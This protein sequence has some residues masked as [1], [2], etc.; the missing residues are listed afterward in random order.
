MRRS[1]VSLL[2][3]LSFLVPACGDGDEEAPFRD[4]MHLQYEFGIGVDAALIDVHVKKDGDEHWAI[5]IQAV[6]D[7]EEREPTT[8]R[9]DRFGKTPSG[10]VAR[11][12][13]PPLWLPPGMREA[14][15]AVV[16]D[17]S[18]SIRTKGKTWNGYDVLVA[19]GA[20]GLGMVEWYFHKDTGF[21]VGTYA[22]SM[23]SAMQMKL[24]KSNVA[25]LSAAR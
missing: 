5:E 18:L 6:D 12:L 20:A 10:N 15:E 22:E 8:I 23:G 19:G 1:V 4:G 16:D 11:L 21:L 14:G 25:G 7:E 13:G 9:V 17:G 3:A 24:V 2:A